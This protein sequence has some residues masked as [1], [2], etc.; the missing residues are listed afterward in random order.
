VLGH[1]VLDERDALATWLVAESVGCGVPV[2][3]A[4]EALK[5]ASV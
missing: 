1:E 5:A 2:V 4:N 3:D